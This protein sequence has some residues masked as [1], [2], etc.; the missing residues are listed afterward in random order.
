MKF[1]HPNICPTALMEFNES[2]AVVVRRYHVRGSLRDLM[3]SVKKPSGNYW[4]KY[5]LRKGQRKFETADLRLI[6]YQILVG[7]SFL[8]SKSIAHGKLFEDEYTPV[9]FI[10]NRFISNQA[11]IPE[12]LSNF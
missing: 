3:Y 10:S 7:L 1:Q 2:G 8:H 9:Y 4:S 6:G 11:Q 5:A 12:N